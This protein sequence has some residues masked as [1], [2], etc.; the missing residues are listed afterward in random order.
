MATDAKV[1]TLGIGA[2][3]TAIGG[4]ACCVLPM[5]MGF[6]GIGSV[7]LA[8]R[9]EPFRPLFIV[10]TAAFLGFGFYQAYRKPTCRPGE[11]CAVPAN[12]GRQRILLWVVTVISVL[13]LG[14]PYYAVYLF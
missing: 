12:R 7:A 13:T 14:F 11:A 1:G 3:L 9:L 4:S 10:L 5:V 6:F 8:A 2:V